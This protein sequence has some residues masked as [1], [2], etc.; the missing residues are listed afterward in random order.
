MPVA[1]RTFNRRRRARRLP[2]AIEWSYDPTPRQREFHECGRRYKLYGGAMGGGKSVAL[3]AE[4]VKL[5]LKFPGN[6][7]YFCRNQITDFRRSTL[8]TFEKLCPPELIKAHYRDER[9]ISFRNGSE[10]TYG[11]LGGEEDL[12][13]IKSTEF[14]WFAIDEATETLEDMFLLLTSRLRWTLPDGSNPDYRA[15]LASNPEPGW[16][17]DRFVDKSMPDHAFIRALPRDNPHLPKD[18]D[19]MLRKNWPDEWV[20]R[21]LEGSWDVFEGQVYKEFEKRLHVYREAEVGEAWDRFRVID[22]GYNNPTCC[23]WIAIDYDGVMWVYDE[24]YERFMTIEENAVVIKAKHP[25]FKGLTLCDPSM[26][27]NTMQKEGKPWSPVDEYRNNGI[28]CTKPY[29]EDGWMTEGMGINLVKQRLK[30]GLLRVH[31]SCVNTVNEF[32][33]YRWRNLKASARGDKNLP[34]E[35]V[36]KDNHAMDCVRMATMWRPAST[37]VP[38]PPEPKNT[39]HYA[40][41]QHKKMLEGPFYAGWN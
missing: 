40:I 15:F 9:I 18:Y 36:D 4:A 21:Y 5:S 6:R 32:L 3:C 25:H 23:L 12:E 27:N 34:E 31:E 10:F 41:M 7:G 30:G 17:K 20:K 37:S 28:F 22:H 2:H 13:K 26:F 33:K 19:A 29:G 11:G 1:L 35:P 14:G 39:L 24:H 8:V 38:V 16:V